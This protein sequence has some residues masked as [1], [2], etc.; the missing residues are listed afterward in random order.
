MR[1]YLTRISALILTMI[2]ILGSISAASATVV[3]SNGNNST[4]KAKS[5]ANTTNTKLDSKTQNSVKTNINPQIV[6]KSTD[7]DWNN[8]NYDPTMSRNSPQTTINST[9]VKQLVVKWKFYTNVSVENSPLIIGNTTYMQNNIMQ[10]FALNLLTGQLLWKYDPKVKNNTA[11]HGISYQNGIIYAPTGS[12][13][14]VMA[15]NAINGQLIWKSPLIDSQKNYYNPSPPIIWQNYI[16]VG[17]GGGDTPP[18]KGSV[19]AL[20]KTTG[21]IIW[22][23]TTCVGSWV[24][25]SKAAVNGG[26]AVWSGGSVDQTRGIIYLPAGNPS[27]DYDATTR[28]GNTSYTNCMIA[29]NITNGHIIWAT[30]FIQVGTVLNVTLPDTHDRDISWGSALVTVSSS[31][32]TSKLVIGH[33]KFGDVMAMNAN[34]GKPLWWTNLHSIN[35]ASATSSIFDY[36]S[37]SD[38][39]TL[40]IQSRPPTGSGTIAALD[41][42][43]G[44]LK[45]KY[46][47]NAQISSP[48]ISN[49]MLFTGNKYTKINS[50]MIMVLNKLTG[51]FIWQTDVGASVTQ[52]G[53]SIGQGM[54]L[55]PTTNDF[56][57]A[58]GLNNLINQSPIIKPNQSSPIVSQ[59]NPNNPVNPT[60]KAKWTNTTHYTGGL[61]FN[62]LVANNIVNKTNVSHDANI[63]M[64]KTGVPILPSLL[65]LLIISGSIIE[66]KLR[67]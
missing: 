28:Q 4:V 43:T 20:N 55:V 34:T 23:I 1:S 62:G 10:V 38:S 42:L 59:P 29:V 26:G 17:G 46:T 56:I 39:N 64:Q 61:V 45:W 30:P 65:G 27:P 54:L 32:G 2:I 6:S 22:H 35:G 50:S 31:K 8:T 14:S 9:N 66:R 21:K 67:K 63:P 53:P 37:A 60:N 48:L 5:I 57:I 49:G 19:T 40:Y 47:V 36:Y 51:L 16:I 13:G 33:D 41:L 25:G 3:S 52:G 24:T 58:F 44:K 7:K 15:L 12:N 11:S 18:L